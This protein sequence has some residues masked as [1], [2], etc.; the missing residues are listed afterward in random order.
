MAARLPSLTSLRAFEAA[1]R[2]LSFTKTA[3]ELNVTQT[4]ISHQIKA[5]EADLGCALF[6]RRARG[7]ALTEAGRRYLAPLTVAFEAIVQ[8]TARAR[9]RESSDVLTVSVLPSFAAK[10]LV[11]RLPRFREGE[12]AI[13]VRVSASHGLVDFARSDVDLA[14]R[15]GKGSWPGVRAELLLRETLAPVCSPRLLEGPRPL[16]EPADLKFYTLLH[17]VWFGAFGDAHDQWREWLAGMG[18][19]GVD[20]RRGP[21]FS[22]S[23]LTIQAAI[24]GMGVALGRSVLFA[25]D[26]AAGRLVR[27]FAAGDRPSLAYYIV[28]PERAFER[29]GVQAFRAWLLAEAKRDDTGSFGTPGPVIG[30]KRRGR[31]SGPRGKSRE[32]GDA[33]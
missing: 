22:D 23:G 7:L 16:T 30:E 20:W 14:I 17:D 2:H 18:A 13:D 3:R 25:D 24:E 9:A 19:D 28:G 33:T 1:G 21:V 5:L 32:G 27:P 26:L 12:P 29:P 15:F 31:K 4:A 10:W 6:V 11:P 8:A